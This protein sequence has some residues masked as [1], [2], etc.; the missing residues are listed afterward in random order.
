MGVAGF[1]IEDPLTCGAPVTA[2]LASSR[3]LSPQERETLRQLADASLAAFGAELGKHTS[4]PVTTWYTE[5]LPP[6][7]EAGPED[8]AFIAACSP[9]A[10]LALLT[11]VTRLTEAREQCTSCRRAESLRRSEQ[12][13]RDAI[14][15]ASSEGSRHE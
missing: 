8:A 9:D 11:E 3:V 1:R 5:D 15:A 10:I 12:E 7:D 6:S 13:T 4:V 14:A 2:P